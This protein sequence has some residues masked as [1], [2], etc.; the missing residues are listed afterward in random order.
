V[1]DL[2]LGRVSADLDL[3]LGLARCP[4]N[5]T[6]AV[7]AEGMEEFCRAHP[8]RGV[9]R[10]AVVSRLSGGAERKAVDV[11]Q[12]CI[13]LDGDG[14]AINVDLLP[15]IGEE[16]YDEMDRIPRRNQR[17]TAEEDSFRRDLT[18]GSM[19]LQVSTRSNP[20]GVGN[21]IGPSGLQ[22]VLKDFHG[23]IEDVCTRTLRCPVPHNNS[24]H[25]V[26]SAVVKTEE[27]E[28]LACSLGLNPTDSP[29]PDETIIE[30]L[31]W[32]KMMKDDPY[33]IL[34]TLR[35][36]ATLDFQIAPSFWLAAPFALRPGSLDAKVSSARKLDELRKVV[37]AGG[38]AQKLLRFF[39]TVLDSP[40]GGAALRDSFFAAP[41]GSIDV[42]DYDRARRLVRQL[43]Q[44]LSVDE[45]VGA[46]LAAA[47]LSCIND[48]GTDSVY[49]AARLISALL[50]V[51]RVCDGLQLPTDIRRAARDSLSIASYL[52]EPLPV[53]ETHSIIA[54]AIA[55]PLPPEPV[56]I[57]DRAQQ[58]A[59]MI[60][61][62]NLLHFDENSA[63]RS[64]SSDPRWIMAVLDVASSCSIKTPRSLVALSTVRNLQ[65]N[66]ETL[67]TCNSEGQ[68]VGP[69]PQGGSLLGRSVANIP[70]IP[71]HLRGQMI[72]TVHV[73]SRLRGDAPII[74]TS[75]DL[76]TYLEINCDGL[77]AKLSDEW[78]DGGIKGTIRPPYAKK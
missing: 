25:T 18:I 49:V 51:D 67:L 56:S 76:R 54:K 16:E 9:S 29:Y 34:R 74:E 78:W 6:V 40:F 47:L 44:D 14:A 11:A 46:V 35:F 52:L 31:W 22:F 21:W 30:T 59:Y 70:E 38:G 28:V 4:P 5:V 48:D 68:L 7:V 12:I 37:K 45:T 23:G 43:P 13:E 42:M 75:D 26:F 72:A 73:L 55:W 50:L 60:H 39:R 65:A 71:P 58:V 27:D 20:S 33:R 3:S 69:S 15:T 62:W 10:V 61:L 8:D 63:R 32:A 1:R 17:G 19:L 77:L 24:V 36:S 57:E 66:I 53:L 64:L 41:L 2:L